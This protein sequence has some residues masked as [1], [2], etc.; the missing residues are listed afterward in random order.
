LGYRPEEVTGL[1]TPDHRHPADA[2]DLEAAFGRARSPGG[3]P[4]LT[5]TRARHRDGT[6]RWLELSITDLRHEPS[7]AGLVFTAR[8]ISERK[9]AEDQLVHQALHDALTGL[10]NRALLVDRL[11]LAISRLERHRNLAAVFLLRLGHL[12]VV[13]DRLPH[14]PGDDGRLGGI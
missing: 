7:V 11:G 4:V 14:P 3:S 6:W 10:P 8:D 5:Q 2:A 12:K 13:K 9:H 1:V